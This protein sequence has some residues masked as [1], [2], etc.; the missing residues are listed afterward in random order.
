[1][2]RNLLL[3]FVVKGAPKK[4][5]I[6]CLIHVSYTFYVFLERIANG[7]IAVFASGLADPLVQALKQLNMSSPGSSFV[8]A[9]L[10]LLAQQ[11]R[12]GGQRTHPVH[13]PACEQGRVEP[14]LAHILPGRSQYALRPGPQLAVFSPAATHLQRGRSVLSRL[15]TLVPKLSSFN[16]CSHPYSLSLLQGMRASDSG[17]VF[18]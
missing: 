10:S 1:M 7:P 15:E 17:Y 9:C 3:V 16:S 8:A 5:V 6:E 2:N 11:S 4:G 13:F 14:G 12:G 18:Q